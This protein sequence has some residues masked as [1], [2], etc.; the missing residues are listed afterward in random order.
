[1]KR[2]EQDIDEAPIPGLAA[3]RE[4]TPPPSLV[5]SVMQRIAEPRPQSFWSWILRPRRIQLRVS[6]LG[7]VGALCAGALAIFTVS[8]TRPK[9]P[10]PTLAPLALTQPAS[11]TVTPAD[12]GDGVVLVRFVLVA[13]GAKKVAVTG[14]FNG[15][16]L[17]G[18]TLDNADGQGTFAGTVALPRGPHEY[19][20]LVDGE[21]VTDPA[22]TETRPDGFG[23]SNAILRL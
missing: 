7:A 22:A 12:R 6:P 8:V 17:E 1:M 4:V 14:N 15:W 5:P 20:F 13:K 18:T 21:W 23:R 10:A 19:M 2:T 9:L 16:S 11:V 3:L